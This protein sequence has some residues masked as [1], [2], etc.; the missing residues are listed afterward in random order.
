M[1]VL[2]PVMH[3]SV[4]SSSEYV[5]A[6]VS[7]LSGQRHGSIRG[8]ETSEDSNEIEAEVLAFVSVESSHPVSLGAA[9]NA[10]LLLLCATFAHF[11]KV[12]PAAVL[13][14]CSLT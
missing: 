8:I 1:R 9:V 14:V 3:V 6:I 12:G 7:D 13:P 5:G 2:K 11:G 10:D 4:R